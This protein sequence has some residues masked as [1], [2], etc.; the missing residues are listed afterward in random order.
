MSFPLNYVQGSTK[1]R[2]LISRCQHSVMR[3]FQ[4]P[5]GQSSACSICNSIKL[6]TYSLPQKLKAGRRK[7]EKSEATSEEV[8]G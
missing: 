4:D 1:Y 5:P 7:T 6:R 8:L 2:S 3:I